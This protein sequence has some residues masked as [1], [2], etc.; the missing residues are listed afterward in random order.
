MSLIVCPV[1]RHQPYAP[2]PTFIHIPSS[3]HHFIRPCYPLLPSQAT[4]SFHPQPIIFPHPLDPALTRQLPP[5][6][7]HPVIAPNLTLFVCHGMNRLGVLAD[8]REK[9]QRRY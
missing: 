5:W 8:T 6:I 3:L 1:H 9:D 2:P 4:S 7:L